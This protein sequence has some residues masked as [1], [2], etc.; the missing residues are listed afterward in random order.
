[1]LVLSTVL[2]TVKQ[3][4]LEKAGNQKQ[5]IMTLRPVQYVKKRT[6]YVVRIALARLKT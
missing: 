4:M 6:A 5:L 1:M 2:E 3:L